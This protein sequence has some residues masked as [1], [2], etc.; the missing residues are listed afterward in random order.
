[1]G[2]HKGDLVNIKDE[3]TEGG[4]SDPILEDWATVQSSQVVQEFHGK[5]RYIVLM[6]YF[7]RDIKGR[8]AYAYAYAHEEGFHRVRYI[9]EQ[10]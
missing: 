2:L 3:L 5:E 8:L 9:S 6:R 1:M 7:L 10:V 4:K